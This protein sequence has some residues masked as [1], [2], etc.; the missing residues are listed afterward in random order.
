M[1]D[2]S[3]IDALKAQLA[4]LSP[5][6]AWGNAAPAGDSELDNVGVPIKI[7]TP[8]GKV[9][10]QVPASVLLSS[11]PQQTM[12]QINAMLQQIAGAGYEIDAW[13]QKQN[14]W[15]HNGGNRGGWNNGGGGGNGWNGGG[16]R[17]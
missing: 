1:T 2:Q 15:G 5:A 11:N 9:R 8:I 10:L 3:Q 14:N 12:M 4:A 13:Q 6:S 17:W 7:E 16:R